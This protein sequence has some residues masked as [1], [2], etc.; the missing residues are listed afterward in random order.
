MNTLDRVR[1]FIDQK[2]TGK[3]QPHI[4]ISYPNIFPKIKNR[5]HFQFQ[6]RLLNT[7]KSICD[8]NHNTSM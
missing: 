8:P 3:Y 7:P 5:S 6:I 1:M 2:L 4:D